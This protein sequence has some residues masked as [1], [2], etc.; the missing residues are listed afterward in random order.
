[1]GGALAAVTALALS[2]VADPP[3]VSTVLDAEL[4]AAVAGGYPERRPIVAVYQRGAPIP[5]V[6]DRRSWSLPRLGVLYA[7]LNAAEV[8]TLARSGHVERIGFDHAGG[9]DMAEARPLTHVDLVNAASLDGAGLKVAVLD[10]GADLDHPDFAGR[11]IDQHCACANDCCPSG[12][13]TQIGPGSAEDGHGHGTNVT[14]IL[15]GGGRAAAPGVAWKAD[16]V[17]IKVLDD[18]NRFST[19]AQITRGLEWLAQHHPD[20]TAVNLSLGTDARYPGWC[21]DASAGNVAMARA[22]DALRTAGAMVFASSGN[23]GSST[24][25]EAPACL[26]NVTAVAAV[27][28]EAQGRQTR[29]GC[30][31]DTAADQVTCFSDLSATTDMLAPGATIRSSGLGGGASAFSGTS[32]ASPQVAGCAVLLTQHDAARRGE[33]VIASMQR[34]GDLVTASRVGRDIPRLNCARA[35]AEL[36]DLIFLAGFQ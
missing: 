33:E 31:E 26:S 8:I 5:A 22:V 18:D 21:D 36:S 15:A 6:A 35:V 14:G 1:M 9:G 19:T 20:V 23:G 12:G 16:I 11:I 17:A 3:P 2:W 7:T 10:S 29:F 30:T 32:Q 25:M 27:W 24:R 13:D 34:G 4:A 28:D